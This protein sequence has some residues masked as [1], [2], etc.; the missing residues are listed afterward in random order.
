MFTSHNAALNIVD[1]E[2]TTAQSITLGENIPP[3]ETI[4]SF[5]EKTSR[6]LS[7]KCRKKQCNQETANKCNKLEFLYFLASFYR[8]FF[9]MCTLDL[10]TRISYPM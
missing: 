1:D 8:F 3:D 9:S 10:Q 7:S 5:T 4:R 6:R 2:N